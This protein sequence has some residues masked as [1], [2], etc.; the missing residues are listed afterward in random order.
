MGESTDLVT[1]IE[2][3]HARATEARSADGLLGEIEDL[4]AEGYLEALTGEARS[5]RLAERLGELVEIV[6]QREA[7]LEMRRIAVQK[8]GV[9]ARVSVL[10]DR[11]A[12][13]REQFAQLRAVSRSR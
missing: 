9:D 13:L 8:R 6:D 4:L 11:L 2:R 10:R 5:R 3:L 12:E 1:R 7:A